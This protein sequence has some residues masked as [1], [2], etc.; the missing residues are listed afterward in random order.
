MGDVLEP[1]PLGVTAP[2]LNPRKRHSVPCARIVK[3]SRGSK[4]PE[5]RA[6]PR[7]V[8]CGS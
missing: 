2:L 7:R 4:R 6:V 5:L 8:T 1:E 3:R